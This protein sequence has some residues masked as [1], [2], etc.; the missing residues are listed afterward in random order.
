VPGAGAQDENDGA[1][2]GGTSASAVGSLLQPLL[3]AASSAAGAGADRPG[4]LLGAA[5]RGLVGVSHDAEA[6]AAA[7]ALLQ[8]V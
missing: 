4:A 1:L 8:Q 7:Q 5:M 6:L 3:R 2:Q